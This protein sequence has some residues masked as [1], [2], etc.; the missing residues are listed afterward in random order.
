[1]G[2]CFCIYNITKKETVDRDWRGYATCEAK[3]VMKKCNWSV[4]DLI[5]T[6]CYDT[7]CMLI[8][9]KNGHPEAIDITHLYMYLTEDKYEETAKNALK[10][11]IDYHV[12]HGGELD[13]DENDPII[14][15]KL[16]KVLKSLSSDDKIEYK[17]LKY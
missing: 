15:D 4:D 6:G 12:Q 10:S 9:D 16:V 2:R 17:V 7:T 8:F 11:H 1:M 5:Y 14:I 13:Y 3:K